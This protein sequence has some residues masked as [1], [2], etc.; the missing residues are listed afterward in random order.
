[1]KWAPL[2][3]EEIRRLYALGQTQEEIGAAFGCTRRRIA[4][5][6]KRAGIAVRPGQFA[7]GH[8]AYGRKHG[9]LENPEYSPYLNMIA[10][11]ENAR[12]ISYPYY[13]ERGIRVCPEW[14]R[15]FNQ[16]LS[17]MGPRP[18]SKYTLDRYP[19]PDGNYEP[20]NVR[21][22][23]RKTQ[24]RNRSNNR[25]VASGGVE[26]CVAEWAERLGAH[27]QTIRRR[28]RVGWSVDDAVSVP[29][30]SGNRIAEATR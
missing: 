1:M 5:H 8:A 3:I 14:R 7:D 26:L 16:F 18:S 21:W 28:L 2:P 15:S 12:H 20:G 10:R 17:D 9:G 19:N 6:M 29:P 4:I 27:H 13:G 30:Y 23:N 22:A 24:A 25:R 11:C